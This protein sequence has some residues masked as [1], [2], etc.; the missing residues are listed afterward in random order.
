MVVWVRSCCEKL[1]RRPDRGTGRM[2]YMMGISRAVLVGDKMFFPA[3][4]FKTFSGAT[5]LDG[6][7]PDYRFKTPVYRTGA[8]D[9][10]LAGGRSGDGP[11]VAASGS[12]WSSLFRARRARP[13]QRPPR[14]GRWPADAGLRQVPAL[15]SQGVAR[16][17]RSNYPASPGRR[18]GG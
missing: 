5:V 7:G 15:Q 1:C 9:Q 17:R 11:H 4:T 10:G 16:L 14:P 2:V 3:T 12:S 8:L 18:A 6:Y 13:R